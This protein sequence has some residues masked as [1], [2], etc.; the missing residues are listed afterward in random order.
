MLVRGE[1]IYQGNNKRSIRLTVDKGR[2]GFNYV[3]DIKSTDRSIDGC[4]NKDSYMYR[5]MDK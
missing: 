4:M 3:S 5:W 1:D 2:G